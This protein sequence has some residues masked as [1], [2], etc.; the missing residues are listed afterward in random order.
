[1]TTHRIFPV[2][3]VFA[4]LACVACGGVASSDLGSQPTGTAGG[5]SGVSG[6]SS[7]S[8]DGDAGLCGAVVR[9]AKADWDPK[10]ARPSSA[11]MSVTFELKNK[12]IV[13]TS[14]RPID[15]VP[16]GR[17]DQVFEEGK[18]SGAWIELRDGGKSLLFQNNIYDPL[19]T[20][21]EGAPD[22]NNPDS[23]WLNATVCPKEGVTFR[24]DV[25]NP[26]NA[27]EMRVY[28]DGLI[29]WF[30]LPVRGG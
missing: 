25:P 24:V 19:S 10:I 27:T 28:A 12:R 22:P 21:E 8:A 2:V 14:V 30:V 7:G 26:T 1:M 9:P 5:S 4:L 3:T 29:G 23:G 15:V 17:T 20:R 16:A 11:G 13:I 6:S 18:T